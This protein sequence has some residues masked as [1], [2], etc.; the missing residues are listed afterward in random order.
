LNDTYCYAD[1]DYNIYHCAVDQEL[2]KAEIAKNQKNGVDTHSLAVDPLFVDPANG[3]FRF[4]PDSPALKMGMVP[5]DITKI[6]LRDGA[7]Q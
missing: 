3:D 6:G 5:I 4:R 2:G 7:M 1:T